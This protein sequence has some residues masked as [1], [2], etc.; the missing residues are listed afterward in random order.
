MLR[1]T[2]LL[3]AVM[4]LTI[5]SLSPPVAWT[6]GSEPPVAGHATG[7]SAKGNDGKGGGTA[8]SCRACTPDVC[9]AAP[10]GFAPFDEKCKDK[11]T[12]RS[13]VATDGSSCSPQAGCCP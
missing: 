8:C 3:A 7:E 5:A 2:R 9:C 1:T 4:W 10:T 13:W 11:C 12:T 6:A